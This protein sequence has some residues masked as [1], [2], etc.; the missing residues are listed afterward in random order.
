MR[1]RAGH[2]YPDYLNIYADRGN[3]AVLERRAA[4]RGH[5]LVDVAP[6][7]PGAANVLRV[8]GAVVAHAG[9]PRTLDR[10]SRLGYDVRTLDVSEFLKTEAA[11]TCK[12]LLIGRQ[13]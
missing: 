11:V 9:F 6:E 8:A 2:L 5:E 1:I 10:V 7:E 13:Q 4:L 3:L 12:S